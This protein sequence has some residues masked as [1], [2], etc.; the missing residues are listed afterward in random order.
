LAFAWIAS[1]ISAA[2]L[3]WRWIVAARAVDRWV[4]P[5]CDLPL[6]KKVLW[7]RYPPQ[8]CPH[9]GQHIIPA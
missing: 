9:R 2:I 5:Q 8:D 1:A 7:W 6:P 4:C 3:L